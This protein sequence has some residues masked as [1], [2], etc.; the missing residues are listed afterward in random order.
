M[1]WGANK[2]YILDE[3]WLLVSSK[4]FTYPFYMITVENSLYMTGQLNLW[5]LDENL[6]TLIQYDATGSAPYFVGLYFNPNNRFLYVAPY[7]FSVIY[8]FNLNLT[9]NH[10]FS[11]STYKPYS[12]TG[13][14][15]QLYIG[16][17]NGTVLVVQNEIIL[18]QFNGCGGNS[19]VLTSILFD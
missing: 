8:V 7:A 4:V 3:N 9:F 16:T 17:L 2:V 15:N 12:I 18:N 11:T 10:S 6:N 5:K 19:V 13:Y 14:N 1:D